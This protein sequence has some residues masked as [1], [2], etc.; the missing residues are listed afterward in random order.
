M[1]WHK[2]DRSQPENLDFM[3]RFR[4]LTDKYANRMAVAEIGDDDNIACCVAYT[5][6]GLLHTAYSFSLL[7]VTYGAAVVRKMMG[8]FKAKVEKSWPSWAFSNH[9]TP[10]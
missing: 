2:Y 10:R 8:D 5:A 1:Q 9:D 3:R 7:T 4:T 6:P